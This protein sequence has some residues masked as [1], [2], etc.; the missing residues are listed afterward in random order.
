[1]I[2]DA[3]SALVN[4]GYTGKAAR[5]VLEKTMSRLGDVGL[6]TLIREALRII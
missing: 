4:L 3:L 6:E 1:M 2:D 5:A